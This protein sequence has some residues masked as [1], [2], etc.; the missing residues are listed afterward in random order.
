[1]GPVSN[2]DS[3]RLLQNARSVFISSSR[4]RS[5]WGALYHTEVVR[6]Q[7]IGSCVGTLSVVALGFALLPL[8]SN[9]SESTAALAFVVPVVLGA[10]IGGFVAGVFSVAAGFLVYDFGYIHPYGTL[11]VGTTEDWAALVVY[12]VV[13]VIV[14]RVVASLNTSRDQAQRGDEAAHH[15]SALSELLV[16]TR[17]VDELLT[18]IVSAV[19]SVFGVAGVSLL[20][21]DGGHLRVASSAG[22]TLSDEDVRRL[23]PQSGQPVA[24]AAAA[25]APEDLRTIA[26][27]AS[28]RPVGILAVRGLPASDADRAVLNTFANDAALAL[29]R[30]QLREQALRTQFLEEVDHFRQSLL[31]AVSHDLRTPLATIKVASSTL[32]HH[33]DTLTRDQAEELYG[34]IEVESDRLSRLVSNLLDITRIEGGVLRV[35]PVATPVVALIRDAVD[36]MRS[37]LDDQ[38]IEMHI[39]DESLHVLVDPLLFGQVLINLLDNAL[40]HSPPGGAISIAVTSDDE[41]VSVSV[42]DEGPGIPPDER[43]A[44]FERFARLDASGRAGLGL[45]IAKTFVEAH[46][47]SIRYEPAVPRGATFVVTLARSESP[48]V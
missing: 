32:L 25:S 45:T 2:R 48:G 27:S 34:L 38:V 28:G 6:R 47:Q 40:R 4:A 14:A 31:G 22:E 7:L 39:P 10:A 35:S 42:S 23:D 36:A 17:P 16:G 26:L 24:L 29:E 46:G 43:E 9:I 18:T 19:H 21:L 37:S 33:G 8:R 12:V 30:A 3:E 1:M 5:L 13:M 44:V 20:V 41:R 11:N 15:L